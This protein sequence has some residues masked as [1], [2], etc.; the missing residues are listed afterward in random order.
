MFHVRLAE[1]H[2]PLIWFYFPR[3]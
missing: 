1:N 3:L 2:A